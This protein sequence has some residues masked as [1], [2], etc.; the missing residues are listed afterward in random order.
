MVLAKKVE[1]D[2][3]ARAQ[4][5][6]GQGLQPPAAGRRGDRRGVRHYAEALVAR[7][8][9]TSCTSG[10]RSARRSRC[11]S[12]AP[13]RPC[14]T[15]TTAPT[16]SFLLAGGGGAMAGADLARAGSSGY[17]AKAYVTRVGAARSSTDA[18]QAEAEMLR[19]P[20]SSATPAG[21]GAAAGWTR[22]A[23]LRGQGQRA[24]RAVRD[25]AGGA[26]AWNGS[27]WPSPT[28]STAR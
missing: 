18:Q 12:R 15:S 25:Q 22:G 19:R 28:G 27:R 5:A 24:H 4:P 21:P 3:A 16:R 1:A 17:T 9:D 26:R 11:C 14:S 6:A 23:P 20:T 2:R 8:A 7:I 10:T 13:R